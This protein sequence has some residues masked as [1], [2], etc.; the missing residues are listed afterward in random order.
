MLGITLTGDEIVS[1]AN[2]GD[3]ED[4]VTDV[5]ATHDQ[6]SQRFLRGWKNKRRANKDGLGSSL[7]NK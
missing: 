1:Q 3:D 5:I 2:A 4:R 6:N 7:P